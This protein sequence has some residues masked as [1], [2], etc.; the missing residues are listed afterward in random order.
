MAQREMCSSYCL[1]P[2]LLPDTTHLFPS[3]KKQVRSRDKQRRR[4]VIR[5]VCR[6]PS[7]PRRNFN[8]SAMILNSAFI[9]AVARKGLGSCTILSRTTSGAQAG[10]A[11]LWWCLLC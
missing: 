6:V 11:L 5:A 7:L 8:I 9:F 1:E 10:Q 2:E 3:Q 4:G